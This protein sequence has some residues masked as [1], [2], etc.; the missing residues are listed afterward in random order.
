M[1]TFRVYMIET[2]VG[3][4]VQMT[5]AQVSGILDSRRP[6]RDMGWQNL[7]AKKRLQVDHSS[8]VTAEVM[9]ADHLGMEIVLRIDQGLAGTWTA[10]LLA[11][12]KDR[13]IPLGR[14]SLEHGV[15]RAI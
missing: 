3:I 7:P 9:E 15:G 5:K 14:L 11:L 1:P 4:L 12:A 2:N 13:A 10:T 8:S 6:P